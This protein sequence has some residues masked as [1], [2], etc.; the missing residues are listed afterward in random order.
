MLASFT[1]EEPYLTLAEL[2]QRTA[3]PKPTVYRLAASLRAAGFMTQ[4]EDGRYGLGFRLLELGAVVRGNLDIVRTCSAGMQRLADATG[5]TVILGQVDWAARE[6][7]IVHRLDSTHTLSVLSPIG[8]RSHLPPGCLGKA[9]LM[10][11]SQADRRRMLAE[12][13]LPASTS[14]SHTDKRALAAELERQSRLGY[15]TEQNEYLDDVS[16]VGAPVVYDGGWPLAAVGVVGP[17][18]RL[19]GKL[20]EIGAM[21]ATVAGD[22]RAPVLAADDSA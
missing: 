1:L 13:E 9:L 15:V 10:G 17:S 21:V 5:E 12:I 8:R 18:T 16:G 6:V 2:A 11:L 4:G 3:L 14:R 7:T 19:A 22:L 20:D